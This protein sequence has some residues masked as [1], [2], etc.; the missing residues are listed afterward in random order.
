MVSIFYDWA[1]L[2]LLKK[3]YQAKGIRA[4]AFLFAAAGFAYT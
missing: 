1:Y 2:W 4:E 3:M